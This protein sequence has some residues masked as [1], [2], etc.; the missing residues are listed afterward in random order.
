MGVMGYSVIVEWV[1]WNTV[2]LLNRCGWYRVIVKWAWW[3]T[4]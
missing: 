4:M 3:D 1:W 2:Q